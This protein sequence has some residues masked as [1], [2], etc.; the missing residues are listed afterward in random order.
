MAQI[1]CTNLHPDLETSSSRPTK[2]FKNN[3]IAS[4]LHSII[5]A[6]NHL[7]FCFSLETECTPR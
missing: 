6:K 7:V 1:S 2:T 3:T 5:L 4:R